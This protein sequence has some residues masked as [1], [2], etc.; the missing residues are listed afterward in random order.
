VTDILLTYKQHIREHLVLIGLFCKITSSDARPPKKC[1]FSAYSV[2][3]E[4]TRQVS[5]L[6]QSH[7]GNLDCFALGL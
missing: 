2:L 5:L 6:S 3:P 4:E 1:F 7:V